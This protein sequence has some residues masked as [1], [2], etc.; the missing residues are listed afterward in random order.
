MT[1]FVGDSTTLPGPKT[2]LNPLGGGADPDEWIAADDYNA[3]REACNDLRSWILDATK[4]V[5]AT[6]SIIAGT[7]LTGGGALSADRT[8]SLAN[9]AVTPGSYTSADLT[10]DAQGRVTAIANGVGGGG[11][12]TSRTLTA[13]T[14]LSGGGDL[15]ANRTFSLANTAVTPGSYTN[16]NITVDAQGRITAASNG[17][18]GGGGLSDGDYGDVV[19]SGGGTIMTV[20]PLPQSRIT[21][22]VSDLAT[23]TA[24]VAALTGGSASAHTLDGDG[25]DGTVSLT[26]TITLTRNM[27]WTTATVASGGCTVNCAGFIPYMKTLDATAGTVVFRMNGNDASG[28]TGGTGHSNVGFLKVNSGSG[29]TGNFNNGPTGNAPAS[30]NWPT[31]FRAGRGGAGGNGSTA[32]GKVGGA[33][34][35]DP[36]LALDTEGTLADFEHWKEMRADLASTTRVCGGS[37]GGAG[38]GSGAAAAGGGGAGGGCCVVI[39]GTVITPA[40]I[41]VQANGGVGGDGTATGCGGGGGGGGGYAG[42]AVLGGGASSV[43]VQANGGAGGASGGG[44]GTQAGSTGPSGQVLRFG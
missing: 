44:T 32:G 33:G 21:N 37:G 11:V 34:G 4:M 30:G 25:H 3:L 23:L 39:C 2:D 19:V 12:P 5:P 22:L 15:T 31:S 42:I 27:Y 41:T 1:N 28:Q 26:G 36:T 6:R 24:A 7:G 38:G 29:A 16:A 17:S 35:T 8:I 40:N 20:D 10:V 13:G 18:G 9:T 14:G 43:T